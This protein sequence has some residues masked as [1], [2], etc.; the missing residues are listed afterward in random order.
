M[1]EVH[2]LR[3]SFGR[4][5]VLRDINLVAP[6]GTV[7]G[8]AGP[9]ACGKSTLMKCL[10]GLVVADAG[11]IR[12]AGRPMENTGEFR[13]FLGYMPQ[14]PQFPRNLSGME[15]L[16]MVE[17]L[18][19]EKAN[20]RND[21]VDYFSLGEALRQPTS[22]L[23]GGTKQKLSA[24][25][26]LMFDAPGILLDEPTAG[27]DPL[28]S[29]QFKRLLRS[30]AEKGKCILLISHL[31][32]EIEQLASRVLFL[33]EGEAVFSGS[34]QQLLDTTRSEGLDQALL[35]I[36]EKRKKQ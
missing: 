20:S 16:N 32:T 4:R 2:G 1:I 22:E 19:G 17:N 5:K 7:T 24:V 21:L 23:S 36:F 29:V 35:H 15:L 8:V 12:I 10:L 33:N 14:N 18:R 34:M 30:E 11:D 28:M 9:N 13:R 6:A 31:I 27:M 3:K 26:A 25:I